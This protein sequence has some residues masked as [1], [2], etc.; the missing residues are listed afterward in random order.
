[1]SV[2]EMLLTRG[3]RQKKTLA[4]LATS[5]L[6]IISKPVWLIARKVARREHQHKV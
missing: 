2:S 4:R 3:T 5:A 1:M 6:W